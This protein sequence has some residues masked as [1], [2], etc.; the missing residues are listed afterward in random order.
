MLPMDGN[1]EGLNSDSLRL[2]S[3]SSTLNNIYMAPSDQTNSENGRLKF[4]KKEFDAKA[5]LQRVF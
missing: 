3:C 1:P 5:E 4:K 2:L